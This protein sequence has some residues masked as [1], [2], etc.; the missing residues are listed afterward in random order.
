MIKKS[1]DKIMRTYMNK[2]NEDL[3]FKDVP[4]SKA[5]IKNKDK[6]IDISAKGLTSLEGS[7]KETGSFNCR[8]NNLKNFK[9]GP[10]I[11]R[12]VFTG[13]FNPV[14]SLVGAPTQVLNGLMSEAK[15]ACVTKGTLSSLEGAPRLVEGDVFLG[16]PAV[17][18]LTG[19]YKHFPE[20]HGMLC[21]LTHDNNFFNI[22]SLFMVKGLKGLIIK[23]MDFDDTPIEIFNAYLAKGKAGL[24][25][26]KS[27]LIKA[28]YDDLAKL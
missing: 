13:S 1:T 6:E 24:L 18:N 27:E 10:E 11:V 26:C 25:A 16:G 12:G 15:F 19:F 2:L 8:N 21:L 17:Q 5:R 28:G 23:N 20:I 4:G 14:T 3:A 7:P 9:Y 22:L